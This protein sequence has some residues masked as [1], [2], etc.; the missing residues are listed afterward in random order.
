MAS[1]P[2]WQ[3]PPPAG[4]DPRETLRWVRRYEVISGLAALVLG[5]V[6]WNEGWWHWLL[7]GVGLLGMSPWPGAQAILRKAERKPN[8]L[9]TDPDRRRARGRRA[10]LVQIPLYLVGGAVLGYQLDGWPAAIFM[11]ALM[12]AGAGLG[13]WRSLRREKT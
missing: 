10:A 9:I 11:G 5:L 4:A 8:V 1:V 7:I 6:L 12:G 2:L 13:A 3:L